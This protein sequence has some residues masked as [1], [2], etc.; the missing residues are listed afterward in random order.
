M[1][2]MDMSVEEQVDVAFRKFNDLVVDQDITDSAISSMPASQTK[3]QMLA[4]R[5]KARNDFCSNVMPAVKKLQSY[6]IKS[7]DDIDPY[8]KGLIE[9]AAQNARL[10]IEKN[11]RLEKA[12]Y[13]GKEIKREVLQKQA[14]K[15]FNALAVFTGIMIVTALIGS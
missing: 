9:Q 13:S 15:E 12:V 14:K 11:T 1:D 10:A 5:K 7:G 3:T 4:E 8:A 6:G 2:Y